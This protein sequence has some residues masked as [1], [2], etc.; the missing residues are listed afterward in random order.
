MKEA[1]H[2]GHSCSSAPYGFGG[3]KASCPI[4]LP[5]ATSQCGPLVSGKLLWEDAT[6]TQRAEPEEIN[7]HSVEPGGP[8]EAHHSQLGERF[9]SRPGLVTCLLLLEPSS[10]LHPECS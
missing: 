1:F 7:I 8:E 6:A 9:P 3:P 10:Y 4:P 2:S 5:T